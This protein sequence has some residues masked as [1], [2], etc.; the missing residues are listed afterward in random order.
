MAVHVQHSSEDGPDQHLHRELCFKI[1]A[2]PKTPLFVFEETNLW[3]LFL[4]GSVFTLGKP[5]IVDLFFHSSG[6]EESNPG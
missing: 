6:Q 3:V 1:E 2:C 4:F 5:P